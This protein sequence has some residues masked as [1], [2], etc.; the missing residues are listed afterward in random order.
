MQMYDCPCLQ[1]LACVTSETHVRRVIQSYVHALTPQQQEHTLEGMEL[2]AIC[3]LNTAT[4]TWVLH[5]AFDAEYHHARINA[6]QRAFACVDVRRAE[7]VPSMFR[8]SSQLPLLDM[9]IEMWQQ[10]VP[11]V[12][13]HFTIYQ[14]A[15][16]VRHLYFLPSSSFYESPFAA[17]LNEMESRANDSLIPFQ[18]VRAWVDEHLFAARVANGLWHC[19]HDT[20]PVGP[21]RSMLRYQVETW[22]EPIGCVVYDSFGEVSLVPLT[23]CVTSLLPLTCCVATC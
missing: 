13:E 5:T 22:D 2:H 6:S 16:V 12:V 9:R 4:N 23:C 7:I 15:S 19:L 10:D 18:T 20:Q 14:H 8:L 3:E 1:V 17:F 21:S 11:N